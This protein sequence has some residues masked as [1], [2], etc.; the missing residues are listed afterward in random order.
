MAL[1]AEGKDPVAANT[2]ETK[3]RYQKKSPILLKNIVVRVPRMVLRGIC[4]KLY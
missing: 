1:L 4:V 3:H 2:T